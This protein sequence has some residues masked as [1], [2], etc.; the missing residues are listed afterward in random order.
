MAS[1]VYYEPA[2]PVPPGGTAS[3]VVSRCRKPECSAVPV[4]CFETGRQTGGVAGLRRAFRRPRLT[5]AVLCAPYIVLC[6]LCCVLSTLSERSAGTGS[7]VLSDMCQTTCRNGARRDARG[8][9]GAAAQSAFSRCGRRPCGPKQTI[10]RPPSPK[11]C[12]TLT[13][14]ALASSA[15]PHAQHYP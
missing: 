9:R 4:T 5:R 8:T 6:A 1:R 3:G 14:R 10:R 11:C 13:R 2:P 15:L 12:A 7:R